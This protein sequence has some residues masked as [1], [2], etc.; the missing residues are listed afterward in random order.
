MKAKKSKARKVLISKLAYDA[1]IAYQKELKA[2]DDQ[3]IFPPADGADKTINHARWLH[4]FFEKYGEDVQSHDFRVTSA[5]MRYAVS[6]DI[7]E[8]SKFLGHSSVTVTQRYLKP[9]ENERLKK[10]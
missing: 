5:T 3:V 2:Q 10:Q 9:D 1:V 7:L 4:R 8:T 6:K